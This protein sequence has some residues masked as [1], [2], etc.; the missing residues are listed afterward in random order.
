MDSSFDLMIIHSKETFDLM[1][2]LLVQKKTD[3]NDYTHFQT[4]LFGFISLGWISLFA[5]IDSK[6]FVAK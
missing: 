1:S 2:E 3:L 6:G 4:Y 5:V